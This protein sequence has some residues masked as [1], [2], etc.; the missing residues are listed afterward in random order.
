MGRGGPGR[1]IKKSVGRGGAS[2]QG[3]GRG[4]GS[5]KHSSKKDLPPSQNGIGKRGSDIIE[6]LHTE[7]LIKEVSW[8]NLLRHHATQTSVTS[9][10]PLP[11]LLCMTV[12]VKQV[13][14][15]FGSSHPDPHEVEKA[16]KV[17]KVR[18]SPCRSVSSSRYF[19]FS[20]L[21][22]DGYCT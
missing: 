1:G 10:C 11:F 12:G 16:K 8:Q 20:K 17:L 9:L 4:R 3:T 22:D 6:I 7:T 2:M 18:S 5:A 19:A 21:T 15:V 13:E 14:K